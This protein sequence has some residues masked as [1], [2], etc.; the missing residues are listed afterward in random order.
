MAFVDAESFQVPKNVFEEFRRDVEGSE[1]DN[2][3]TSQFGT[4]E[5][6]DGIAEVGVDIDHRGEGCGCHRFRDDFVFMRRAREHR[7]SDPAN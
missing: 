4:H 6:V 1:G 7:A 2:S 5:S 3:T